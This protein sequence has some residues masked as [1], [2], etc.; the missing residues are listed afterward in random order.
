M[1][2]FRVWYT[3]PDRLLS[4]CTTVQ[5]L[6]GFLREL[7]LWKFLKITFKIPAKYRVITGRQL[8]QGYYVFGGNSLHPHARGPV[9]MEHRNYEIV[10]KFG[11]HYTVIEPE[12]ILWEKK[13]K[14]LVAAS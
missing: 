12:Y 6:Q 1:R 10:R 5:L 13:S 4:R 9:S 7:S 2:K 11:T 8:Q 14:S 3:I